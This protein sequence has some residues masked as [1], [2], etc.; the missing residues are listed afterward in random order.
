MERIRLKL[1]GFMFDVIHK[2]GK[3]NPSDYLSR[4]PSPISDLTAH[5][6]ENT[7]ELECHAVNVINSNISTA[8]NLS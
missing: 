5:E 3:W 6:L 4:H 7:M 2:P 1:Q 8:F